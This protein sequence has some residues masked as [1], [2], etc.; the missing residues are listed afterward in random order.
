MEN[1]IDTLPQLSA[2]R[3]ALIIVASL[4]L[5]ALV[6][7]FLTAPLAFASQEQTPGMPL[8]FDH[9]KLSFRA[10]RTYQNSAESF[11]AFLAAVLVAIVAGVSPLV[12][13]VAAG[14]YLLARLLFWAFYYSGFGRVAGGPR[15]MAFVLC[16][17]AN[18]L[19]AI[20]A[21]IALF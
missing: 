6:Q 14:V 11:P 10:V 4:S 20:A 18:I 2:Y 8:Q 5:I 15:T 12:L 3:P 17:L 19:I 16:L 13:N 9:S 1:L 7:N 21:L